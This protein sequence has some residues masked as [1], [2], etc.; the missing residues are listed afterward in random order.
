[1]FGLKRSPDSPDIVVL[2]PVLVG[3]TLILGMLVHYLLWPRPLL[4]V[5]PARVLG[6][7]LFVSSS[8]LA[9]L[10]HRAMQ[11]V[12]TN[13]MPTL[14]TVA[15]A[16]DGPY[17]YTRNPLYIAAIGVY[18]GVALW[19]DGWALLLLLF[20]MAFVLHRG[21]VLREEKYLTNKFG[22]TYRSYQS[23]VPRWL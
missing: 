9:H 6:L 21:I 20:P 11:R 13:V 5:V 14:P 19:V 8:V 23:R 3:G 1:M 7:T 2:P 17:R 22:E 10:S 12:G 15:L 16:T 18:L 4:P